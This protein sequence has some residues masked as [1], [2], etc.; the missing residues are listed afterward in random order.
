MESDIHGTW[1]QSNHT[2]EAFCEHRSRGPFMV[3]S[4]GSFCIGQLTDGEEKHPNVS[5]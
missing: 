2:V 5:P 4:N 1:K 3:G